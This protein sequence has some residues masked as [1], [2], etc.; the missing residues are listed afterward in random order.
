MS[1]RQLTVLASALL[2]SGALWAAGA[3]ANGPKPESAQS[4]NEATVSFAR[5]INPILRQRCAVCHVTGQEPGLLS[6]V[7]TKSYGALVGQDSV[8]SNLKR[9]EPGN[10]EQSYLYHK[11]MGSHLEAGGEGLRMPFAA[12]PLNR[13]QTD[14]VKH[15]IEEGARNN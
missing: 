1:T 5:E 15:W 14:L 11:L 10:P 12:P 7:P 9:V 13:A 2:A 3:L 6:L 4:A 8:Q